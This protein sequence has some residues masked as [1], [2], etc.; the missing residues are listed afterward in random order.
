MTTNISD[1][2]IIAEAI[3]LV[4][5]GVKVTFPVKGRSMLPFIVGGRD[6]LIL[7]KPGKL[8]VGQ[9]VLAWVDGYRFVVHRVESLSGKKVTLMGDGNLGQREY[10][11]LPDVKAVATYVVTGKRRR[12]L[13]TRGHRFAAWWWVRLCPIRKYLLFIYRLF[14]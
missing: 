1:N 8:Q 6:S 7:E 3:R 12:S 11:E 5:E 9:V 13:N 14:H 2:V 4:N 10:C